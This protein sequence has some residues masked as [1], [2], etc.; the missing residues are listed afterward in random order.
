MKKDS[1]IFIAGGQGLV[2]S[3]IIRN[4]IS[5]GYTNISASYRGRK[6]SE[7]ELRSGKV[8]FFP[9][10]LLDSAAVDSHFKAEKPEYVYLAAAKVGGIVANNTY[11]ADFIYENLQIQNNMIYA[12]Y[13]HG[14]KKL[15]FLGSSCI[16]PKD[17]P[18][19]MNEDCLLTSPLEY[20]NEPY[21]ISKIAGIKLCESFNIQYGT[22]FISVMPTNLYGYKDNFDLEKSHVLP[23]LI[24]KFHLGMC[25]EKGDE[26]AIRNNFSKNPVEGVDGN[27]DYSEILGKMRKYGITASGGKVMV[28]IWGTGKP[29]REFM[30][31]DD[32]ADACN[33][34]MESIDFSDLSKGMKEVRNTHI[35]IGT[36][37][38]I[39]IADLAD[40]IKGITGFGG[41]IYFNIDKPDGTMKKLQDVGKLNSLGWQASIQLEQGIYGVYGNY[42]NNLG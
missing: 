34:L 22:N 35:N 38:D 11:R 8:G 28:E 32:M 18:Q 29:M 1:R 33:Y 3:A 6:P 19:P 30:H 27:S 15:M 36:G 24:R 17:A 20:T 9:I 25:L 31:A 26:A 5:R 10:D 23:A 13:R 39:S 42:I 14:V 7:D 4:L 16:Y 2:G 21:A 40:M 37:K 12:A 41:D